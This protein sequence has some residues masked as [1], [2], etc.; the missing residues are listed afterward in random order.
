MQLSNERAFLFHW[1][2]LYFVMIIFDLLPLN[3]AELNNESI[4][5]SENT[6]VTLLCA[7]KR[8]G[9]YIGAQH[10]LMVGSKKISLGL[11]N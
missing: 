10:Q 5:V 1:I 9:Q 11:T 7:Q 4:K 2:K 6:K 3:T 8:Y